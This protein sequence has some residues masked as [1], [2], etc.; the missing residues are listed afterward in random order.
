MYMK[1]SKT[2]GRSTYT[3]NTW[4]TNILTKSNISN[5][6]VEYKSAEGFA[7]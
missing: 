2:L 6:P 3:L 1:V 7:I 4:L 5:T